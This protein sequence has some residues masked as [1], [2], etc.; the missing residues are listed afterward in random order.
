MK[1]K[2]VIM[3][4]VAV[5]IFLVPTVYNKVINSVIRYE[6]PEESFE[7]SSPRGNELI[8][9]LEDKG[10]ALLIYKEND[11]ELWNK[12]IAKDSRGWSPLTLEY[13]SKKSKITEKGFVDLR[14]IN[15]KYVVDVMTSTEDKENITGIISDSLNSEFM[16]Y[17]YEFGENKITISGLLVSE[18]K[19]PDDY[20]VIIDGLEVPLY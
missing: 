1:K 12:I 14:E 6:T 9:V 20:K 17:S 18:E 5:I 19:F 10:I 8:E 16:I 7:K 3:I 13:K 4:I 11:Y 2:T 15:G